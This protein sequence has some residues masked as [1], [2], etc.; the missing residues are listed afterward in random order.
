MIECFS[1][2]D[3]V[4]S[5]GREVTSRDLI[6]GEHF[7]YSK[8]NFSVRISLSGHSLV[9]ISCLFHNVLEIEETRFSPCHYL[10]FGECDTRWLDKKTTNYKKNFPIVTM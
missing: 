2:V 5:P 9:Y 10:G 1:N 7:S 3:N 6:T 4:C 8:M